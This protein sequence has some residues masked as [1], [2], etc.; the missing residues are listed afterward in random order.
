MH[1]TVNPK[2]ASAELCINKCKFY[3]F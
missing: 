1:I 2:L 3:M